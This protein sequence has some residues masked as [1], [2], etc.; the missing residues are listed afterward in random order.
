MRRMLSLVNAYLAVTLL[1]GGWGSFVY[2]MINANVTIP[3]PDAAT[4]NKM[5]L[6]GQR[7][8]AIEEAKRLGKKEY[9]YSTSKIPIPVSP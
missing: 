5:G 9:R 7:M 4:A 1:L 8:A 2:V 6:E 3:E